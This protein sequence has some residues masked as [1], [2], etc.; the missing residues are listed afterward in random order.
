MVALSIV[1]SAIPPPLSDVC[2]AKDPPLSSVSTHITLRTYAC[3][4]CTYGA[5]RTIV[6]GPF[7]AA[8]LDPK[9]MYLAFLLTVLYRSRI[10]R[11]LGR[12]G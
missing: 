2:L 11:I 3:S 5:R 10:K 1:C 12:A 6:E 9:S 8:R 4:R 7:L